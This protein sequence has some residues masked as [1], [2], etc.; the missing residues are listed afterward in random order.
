MV[1]SGGVE[2]DDDQVMW[3]GWLGG[4]TGGEQECEAMERC[5]VGGGHVDSSGRGGR[6]ALFG[7]RRVLTPD[8]VQVVLGAQ[9][10][11]LIGD[12]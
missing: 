3:S 5:A 6:L 12:R 9:E 8:A 1:P 11:A 4:S 10:Q 7:R 2:R